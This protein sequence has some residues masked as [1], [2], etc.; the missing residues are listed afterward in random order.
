MSRDWIAR[1]VAFVLGA[2]A[3]L[4]AQQ[5]MGPKNLGECFLQVSETARTNA[6]AEIGFEGCDLLFPTT[7]EA[8]AV[9]PWERDWLKPD[10]EIFGTPASPATSPAP[11]NR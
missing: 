6:A 9:K 4:I 11:T 10:D 5:A 2:S 7:V 8:S 3:V 1:A